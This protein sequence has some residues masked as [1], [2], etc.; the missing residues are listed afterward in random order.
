M[1]LTQHMVIDNSL[2]SAIKSGSKRTAKAEFYRKLIKKAEWKELL[3]EAYLIAPV[4][5]IKNDEDGITPFLE[6]GCFYPHHAMYNEKLILSVPRLRDVFVQTVKSGEYFRNEALK[7]HIERHMEEMG[8]S[9]YKEVFA[10]DFDDIYNYILDMVR[11]WFSKDF[12]RKIEEKEIKRIFRNCF[13]CGSEQERTEL[14]SD[15]I[16][17]LIRSWLAKYSEEE[18]KEKAQTLFEKVKHE[19]AAEGAERWMR[20]DGKH[21]FKASPNDDNKRLAIYVFEDSLWREINWF[22]ILEDVEVTEENAFAFYR[23]LEKT[24]YT[25][26]VYSYYLFLRGM[27]I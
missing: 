22:E 11:D 6:C 4:E 7:N 26:L 24:G 14:D 9:D 12:D 23:S 1:H 17:R 10:S 20:I 16:E 5:K 15:L 13:N 25:W 8:I 2:E 27:E 19:R 18:L 21:Q 3:Q